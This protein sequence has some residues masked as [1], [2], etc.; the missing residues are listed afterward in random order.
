MTFGNSWNTTAIAFTWVFIYKQDST[1]FFCEIVH[2]NTEITSFFH[3][4]SSIK[5]KLARL[6]S[7]LIYSEI[8]QVLMNFSCV[9][10]SL[11]NCLYCQQWKQGGDWKPVI[12]STID[13][14]GYFL[15]KDLTEP[16][17]FPCL[18]DQY[19]P[20]INLH[21]AHISLSLS[22]TVHKNERSRSI[23]DHWCLLVTMKHTGQRNCRGLSLHSYNRK[24]LSI[25]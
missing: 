10:K 1:H 7:K 24:Y 16:K 9:G 5:L 22:K 12:F 11:S 6:S 8:W 2:L 3:L 14:R 23:Q 19:L 18:Y 21:Y 4:W 13:L 17:K 20:D 25:Y 15:E